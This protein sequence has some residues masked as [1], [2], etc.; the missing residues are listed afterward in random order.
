MD[1]ILALE[2]NTSTATPYTTQ[3]NLSCKYLEIL[4]L[5]RLSG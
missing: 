3:I 2:D 4:T 5:V 1:N